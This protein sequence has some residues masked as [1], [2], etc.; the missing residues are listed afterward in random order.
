MKGEGI[1][2]TSD[3][4]P[5]VR[6]AWAFTGALLAVVL[7]MAVLVDQLHQQSDASRQAQALAS[8]MESDAA[9]LQAAEDAWDGE[10]GLEARQ[11]ASD[12]LVDLRTKLTVL[13]GLSDE[14]IVPAI[15][16][17]LGTLETALEIQLAHLNAGGLEAMEEVDQQ[18]TD[19]AFE[20]FDE[21][22]ETAH[23][24]FA[25]AADRSLTI[26]RVG[27]WLATLIAGVA[28][29]GLSWRQQRAQRAERNE[30]EQ[31]LRQRAAEV[32]S[33]TEQHRRLDIMKYSF[34]S[35]V[36]HELRTPLTAI[37]LA[38]EMLQDGDVGQLPPDVS[39]VV[40]VAERG[41]R[42]LAR[43]VEDILDLERLESGKFG[44]QLV[45][46]DLHVMLLE[47]VESLAPLAEQ[48]GIELVLHDAH[49]NVLCDGDRVVQALVNLVGN[50]IK[51]TSPGGSIHLETVRRDMEVE[52]TVRDEGRGI[53]VAE[54]D[55]VFD[56][57]HQVDAKVDQGKGGV[58]LGLAI[59]RQLVEA[60]GGRIWVE[61]EYG[62][63]TAF[64]F[65][66][67]MAV[68]EPHDS[69]ALSEPKLL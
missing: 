11:E 56:R 55:S 41:A 7:G 30:I 6:S 13:Q 48:A 51:F 31:R 25:A 24:Y 46:H 19:P 49:A 47:T 35:A 59:T 52:V 54:L 67:P 61:S 36:S 50:A 1:R 42:R 23:A 33:I 27:L 65:T 17:D 3:L 44:F 68:A 66:L 63:G 28:I 4:G 53:P 43:L 29:G 39:R 57:F 15:E 10:Q 32:A 21:R 2:A 16:R 18:R 60:Q 22:V 38:L 14:S 64:H 58:G 69:E 45:P 20:A 34:A 5:V 8:W 9:E 62:V 40:S 26:S 12:E 37:L